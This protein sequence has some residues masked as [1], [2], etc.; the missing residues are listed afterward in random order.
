[1]CKSLKQRGTLV[2][3]EERKLAFHSYLFKD[4][5]RFTGLLVKKKITATIFT[6]NT[7]TKLRVL[8]WPKWQRCYKLP[9]KLIQLVLI[10][11]LRKG[12]TLNINKPVSS[13]W[14][15]DTLFPDTLQGIEWPCYC[16]KKETMEGED[17]RHSVPVT[18]ERSTI[19]KMAK[20]TCHHL[21]RHCG[22]HLSF[23]PC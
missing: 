7:S 5:T 4:A 14:V 16:S 2:M 20:N 12:N 15:A 10:H 21:K 1:M 22:W 3:I 8:L 11:Q 17:I 6:Q 23:S 18:W 13:R 19:A 9:T